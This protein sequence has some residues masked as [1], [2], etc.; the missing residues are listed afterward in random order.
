MCSAP[1]SGFGKARTRWRAAGV[2]PARR[3]HRYVNNN[4]GILRLRIRASWRPARSVE[5]QMLRRG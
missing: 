3:Q 5:E 1:V 4:C 2:L